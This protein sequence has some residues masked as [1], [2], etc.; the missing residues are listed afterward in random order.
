[1]LKSSRRSTK[2]RRSL[3]PSMKRKKES[4]RLYG[5]VVRVKSAARLIELAAGDHTLNEADRVASALL[6]A[7]KSLAR[8]AGELHQNRWRVAP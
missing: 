1:M 7:K 4:Q 5:I 2:L 8:A 6:A 3:I